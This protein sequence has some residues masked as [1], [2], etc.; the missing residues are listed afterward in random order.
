MLRP[1][2][3]FLPTFGTS[4]HKKQESGAEYYLTAVSMVWILD[5]C[6]SDY[7]VPN[8]RQNASEKK[9]HN[10][11]WLSLWSLSTYIIDMIWTINKNNRKNNL[12]TDGVFYSEDVSLRRILWKDTGDCTIVWWSEISSLIDNLFYIWQKK[13][14]TAGPP[15]V[16]IPGKL[17]QEFSI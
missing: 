12:L 1:G 14:H 7:Q 10:F 4:L 8:K 3:N 11:V 16:W 2:I 9:K 15:R 13:M 17:W 5:S 6:L